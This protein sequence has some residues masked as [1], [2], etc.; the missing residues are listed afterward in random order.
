MRGVGDEPL[1]PVDDPAAVGAGGGAAHARRVRPGLR[2][3]QRERGH[4]AALGH[5]LQ[6][7]LLLRVGAVADQHLPG[8][9]VV[10]AEERP[11]RQRR[12]P[13]LQRQLHVLREVQAEP[14]VL[15][16]DRVAEQAHLRRLRPQVVRH[17]V[18][19]GDLALP[20]HDRVPHELPHLR[21]DR[22]EVLGGDGHRRSVRSAVASRAAIAP[23]AT[24]AAIGRARALAAERHQR[25]HQ[26]P[27]REHQRPEDRRRGA[28]GGRLLHAE[29]RRVGRHQAAAWP[30]RR[31]AAPAPRPGSTPAST[32]TSSTAAATVEPASPTTSRRRT[33]NRRTSRALSNP[34]TII[35]A[36]LSREHQAELRGGEPVDVLQRE[37]GAGDV[38]EQRGVGE[39]DRQRVAGEH[40]VAGQ[41][42]ERP[43]GLPQPTGVPPLDGQGLRDQPPR[44]ER[45]HQ[46]DRRQQPEHRPPAARS[47]PAARHRAPAP[48]IGATLDTVMN[49]ENSRAAATPS[50]TSAAIARA[51]TIPPP[52]DAPCTNRHTVSQPAD[53]ASAHSTEATAQT[54]VDPM[55]SP[56]RPRASD[57]G[58]STSWPTTSPMTSAVSVSCTAAWLA[59]RS[60][61]SCGE[62]R[63]VEV[64][65]QRAEGGEAAQEHG[66]HGESAAGEGWSGHASSVGRYHRSV[67]HNVSSTINR[68]FRWMLA[69]SSTSSRSP[70]S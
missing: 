12:V 49:S 51:S 44:R 35:P 41:A 66:E 6:P 18:G 23:P 21:H 58:P 33:G 13:E 9:P 10:R 2:L 59:P 52:P 38:A 63:E 60:A 5:R 54:S 22:A 67:Q 14:A 8:D 55:S 68:G 50:A 28:R 7:P 62:R 29:H 37:R 43:P 61:A 31:T 45:E 46:A 26:H 24:T 16:G 47:R 48:T 25:G 36:A 57:S 70:R 27:A 19:V 3:G 39:G 11:E 65:R 30:P 15:L 1:L 69:S 56:R 42:D 34:S 4:H 32:A 64:H 40:A 20:R 53:G 17:G